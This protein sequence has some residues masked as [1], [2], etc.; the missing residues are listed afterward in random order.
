[1]HKFLKQQNGKHCWKKQPWGWPLA[2]RSTR[3]VVLLR[4]AHVERVPPYIRRWDEIKESRVCRV[5]NTPASG[6]LFTSAAG[7][8]SC[9]SHI[10]TW[11]IRGKLSAK[12]S[13]FPTFTWC[14]FYMVQSLTTQSKLFLCFCW[15]KWNFQLDEPS[16]KGKK[17]W[18]RA[19]WKC[20]WERE[21]KRLSSPLEQWVPYNPPTAELG[22]EL[23]DSLLYTHHTYP[24]LSGCHQEHC[25]L[26]AQASSGSCCCASS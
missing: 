19:L 23:S 20:Y 18:H 7:R 8:M 26:P 2:I 5:N 11:L 17:R 9:V 24:Q 21:G 14:P 13:S 15:W 10:K 25:S 6:K 16:R 12:V 22:K 1:M 4:L 3:T